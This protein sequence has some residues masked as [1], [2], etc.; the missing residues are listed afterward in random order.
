LTI[1]IIH[2]A[3][4][5]VPAFVYGAILEYRIE[6]IMF[7]RDVGMKLSIL[8]A[9]RDAA[10]DLNLAALLNKKDEIPENFWNSARKTNDKTKVSTDKFNKYIN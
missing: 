2:G 10:G 4:L 3:A 9:Y 1:T 7:P 8:T 5:L 6:K